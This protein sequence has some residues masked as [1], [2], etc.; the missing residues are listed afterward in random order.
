MT[1]KIEAIQRAVI[2]NF[3]VT[4]EQELKSSIFAKVDEF[5]KISPE[6]YKDMLQAIKDGKTRLAETL[7]KKNSRDDNCLGS[8]SII[9]VDHMPF[10]IHQTDPIV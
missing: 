8:I 1:V 3:E 5:Q 6:G 7:L 10:D 2:P 4:S 9:H